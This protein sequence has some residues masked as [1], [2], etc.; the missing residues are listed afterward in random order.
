ME[1]EGERWSEGEGRSQM[2]L[3]ESE[4]NFSL[5]FFTKKMLQRQGTKEGRAD[6]TKVIQARLFLYFRSTY[7]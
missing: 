1:E 7:I 4:T 3:R 6:K 2:I 5:Y